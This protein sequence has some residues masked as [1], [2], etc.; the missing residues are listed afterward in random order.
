LVAAALINDN[1][2]QNLDLYGMQTAEDHSTA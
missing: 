2:I 1:V